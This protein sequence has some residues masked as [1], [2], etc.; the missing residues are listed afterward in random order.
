MLEKLAN[1]E[2]AVFFL[3]LF[4]ATFLVAWL[5]TLVWSKG[6][7]LA[8]SAKEKAPTKKS[9]GFLTTLFIFLFVVI[10]LL[11]LA[12]ARF[13][14]S[15]TSHQLVAIVEC[16]PSQE[17]SGEAFELVL[18]RVLDGE[19]QPSESFIIRGEDWTLGGDI[20]EWQSFMNIIGLK[21]M[22]RL[23]RLQGRYDEADEE[24]T[25][26]ITAYALVEDEKSPFWET[27]YNIAVKTP[28]IKS[29]HQNFVATHPFFG[30][31]FKVYVTPTGYTLERFKG[32]K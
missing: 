31:Y 20:L 8:E 7:A 15:F 32:N 28:I 4:V 30:D 24:M 21:S 12:V 5:L 9:M 17:Y 19:H 26:K 25:E 1:A 29:A 2:P 22:Y 13:Y 18:T 10:V 11:V 14:T 23:T 27:L 16:Y 6:K 3:A